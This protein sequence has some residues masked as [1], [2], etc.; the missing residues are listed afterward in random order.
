MIKELNHE[1]MQQIAGGELVTATIILVGA[2]VGGFALGVGL[3]NDI[4]SLVTD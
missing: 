3:Y 1:E 4:K 2:A